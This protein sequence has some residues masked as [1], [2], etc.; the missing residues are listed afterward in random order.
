[1]LP[2]RWVRRRPVRRLRRHQHRRPRRALPYPRLRALPTSRRAP[3]VPFTASDADP[4]CCSFL[5]GCFSS[6]T[7]A[8]TA[9]APFPTL[10]CSADLSSIRC[11]SNVSSTSELFEEEKY[12]NSSFNRLIRWDVS[13]AVLAYIYSYTLNNWAVFGE[14]FSRTPD[15]ATFVRNAFWL[16]LS[17]EYGCRLFYHWNILWYIAIINNKNKYRYQ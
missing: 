9:G 16:S 5:C 12:F 10:S 11:V 17:S 7:I 15:H 6:P 14:L 3:A 4:L 13:H 1:M 8:G 2:M